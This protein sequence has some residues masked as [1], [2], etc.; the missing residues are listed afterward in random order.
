LSLRRCIYPKDSDFAHPLLG[1]FAASV[2]AGLGTQSFN[3]S[4][5][6]RARVGIEFGEGKGGTIRIKLINFPERSSAWSRKSVTH[7][8]ALRLGSRTNHSGRH[9]LQAA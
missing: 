8:P 6:I 4:C 5:A 2:A 7:F 1:V 9:G 3:L